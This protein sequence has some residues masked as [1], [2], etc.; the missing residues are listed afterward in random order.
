[1]PAKVSEFARVAAA[2]LLRVE[3]STHGGIS[4]LATRLHFRSVMDF[5]EYGGCG[6][7]RIE[8]TEGDVPEFVSV[9][10]CELAS[11]MDEFS[12]CRLIVDDAC[13]LC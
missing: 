3:L 13:M 5:I 1:M 4:G 6:F 10:K 8:M 12:G 11:F 2:P 7:P 9:G